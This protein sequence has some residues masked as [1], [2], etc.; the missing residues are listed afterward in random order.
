MKQ[1]LVLIITTCAIFAGYASHAQLLKSA[2]TP[3][4]YEGLYDAPYDINKLF[5]H[6]QPL[7]ADVFATNLNAGMG[8]EAQYYWDDK[9][10]FKA[11]ARSAYVRAT[12]FTRDVA[13][14]N[15]GMQTIEPYKFTYIEA[16][17]TYHIKDFDQDTETKFILYST[18]YKGAKWAA[19]VPDF[20]KAPTKVRK[21]LGA[22]LGGMAYKTSFDLKRT[23]DEQKIYLYAEDS[24]IMPSV[25][26]AFGNIGV[27]GGYVGGSYSMIKNAA[28]K[29]DKT[30]GVAVSDLIFT[31]YADLIVMPSIVLEDIMYDNKRYYTDG[32]KTSMFGFRVGMEGKFNREFGWAYGAEAGMR[33]G[34]SSRAFFATVK[35]SFP[36]YGATLS[37]EVEAFGK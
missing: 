6:F 15:K 11:H 37:H 7:Y 32:V 30:Y 34:L 26:H 16:G 35:I 29:F 25:D 1:I 24:T 8:L 12:D 17:A 31:A 5:V 23:M 2:S 33:P 27:F 19:K 18:R 4:T 10:D 36:V 20:V 13:E 9:M 14:K 22:R 21:I 3:P 28:I